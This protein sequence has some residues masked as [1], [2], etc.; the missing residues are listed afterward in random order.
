MHHMDISFLYAP[1]IY[2]FLGLCFVTQRSYMHHMDIS[3]LHAQIV[4]VFLCFLF[5]SQRSHMHHMD[6]Y[7][8]HA[9]IVYVF[10]GLVFVTTRSYM[11]YMDISS[12]TESLCVEEVTTITS[13]NIEWKRVSD[14]NF[15]KFKFP[16]NLV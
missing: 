16:E 2:V 5:V 6:I 7:F 10:L 13:W 3:S 9:Q 14:F 11:H 15:P 8:L 12:C 4:C 1:V